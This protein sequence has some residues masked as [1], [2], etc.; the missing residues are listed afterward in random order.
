MRNSG[1]RRASSDSGR[2][3]GENIYRFIDV[4]L[5]DVPLDPLEMNRLALGE[6]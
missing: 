2:P 4:V 1:P 5:Y 6:K 3:W